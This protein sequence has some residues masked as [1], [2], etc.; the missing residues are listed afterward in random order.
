MNGKPAISIEVTKRI[1]TNIIENNDQVREVVANFTKDWPS[2][3]KIN[4]L[5]DQS[6]FIFEVLGSL[7]SSIMTAIVLVMICVVGT[8]GIRSGLLV[9]L[10]IPG[11]FM[12]AFL[13]LGGLGMTVNM[14]VM[15]GMV[16]TVGMLVDGAIVVT[17][18]ADRK[19]AE[20]MSPAD[21]YQRA[22]KLMFWPVVSST[23]TTL[24]AFLPLLLWP[25]VAGQFMSY[26][27][28]MVII[29]LMASL[30]TALI[31]LPVTGTLFAQ[32]ASSVAKRANAV[33]AIVV[34]AIAGLFAYGGPLA[35]FDPAMRLAGGAAVAVIALILAYKISQFITSRRKPK[36]KRA[37]T[38]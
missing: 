5:L 24:A 31:F 34:G 7:Q 15:F 11:S 33:T 27:P 17:E 12:L 19:I 30:M 38:V 29:V 22:A 35:Q 6:S 18:Y 20:G 1:G 13:I 9:G 28:K 2:T 36:P 14:M 3:I 21:A 4:Y 26:L 23:A 32:V 25:G 8:L 10:A 16:L 37:L